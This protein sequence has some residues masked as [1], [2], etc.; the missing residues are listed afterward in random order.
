MEQVKKRKNF[1][2][3]EKNV[4]LDL[5]SEKKTIIENKKTDGTTNEE[6]AK[7]WKHVTESYNSSAQTGCRSIKQLKELYAILKR[8]AR[9]NLAADRAEHFKTGGGSMTPKT[10]DLDEKVAGTVRDH[11]TPDQNAYDSSAALYESV[12]VVKEILP[13][14][15]EEIVVIPSPSGSVIPPIEVNEPILNDLEQKKG[16]RKRSRMYAVDSL[17]AAIQ[18]RKKIKN[19]LSEEEASHK[20]V[21]FQLDIEYKTLLITNIQLKNEHQTLVN[22]QQEMLNKITEIELKTKT[23]YNMNIV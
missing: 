14:P 9:K 13:L 11:F 2:H 21:L 10:T 17:S 12:K 18:N 7:A 20:K 23:N 8:T 16:I 15:L 5:I 4:L 6:K 3:F 19:K 1:T 22:K